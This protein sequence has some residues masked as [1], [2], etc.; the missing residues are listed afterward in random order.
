MTDKKRSCSAYLA[1][2]ES[3]QLQLSDAELAVL[4]GVKQ[5]VTHP[6]VGVN[7]LLE[8]SDQGEVLPDGLLEV[9]DA[10]ALLLG[11]TGDLQLETHALLLL[12]VFLR[13]QKIH[14]T[15]TESG[16][17]T[18]KD[19]ELFTHR[20]L[21]MLQPTLRLGSTCNSRLLTMSRIIAYWT[22]FVEISRSW[23]MRS[24]DT[25]KGSP[26]GQRS[27]NVTTWSG[28]TAP[29][30][31][32]NLPVVVLTIPPTAWP[33]SISSSTESRFRCLCSS[34]AVLTSSHNC[35]SSCSDGLGSMVAKYCIPSSRQ[36]QGV[37]VP[38]RVV[39]T[40]EQLSLRCR[41]QHT[42]GRLRAAQHHLGKAKKPSHDTSSRIDEHSTGFSENKSMMKNRRR[43]L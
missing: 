39:L 1:V 12:T 28:R 15:H 29:C 26:C 22:G 42:A 34:M 6:D 38:G 9:Q 35:R 37:V 33:L 11:V 19:S 2:H 4:F 40:L 30:L 8:T 24:T 18:T 41:H 32:S 7:L 36:V 14:E 43:D 20:D 31:R 3:L 27:R 5:D 21:A 10:A 13:V 17:N 23:W 25:D 16:G